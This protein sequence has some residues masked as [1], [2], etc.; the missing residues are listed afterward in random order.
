MFRTVGLAIAGATLLTLSS[1]AVPATARP[2]E[3]KVAKRLAETG[4]YPYLGPSVAALGPGDVWV[5]D[6]RIHHWNGRRWRTVRPTGTGDKRFAGVLAASKNDVWFITTVDPT[7]QDVQM[8]HWNGRRWR[9]SKPTKDYLGPPRDVTLMP[10][11]D[12]WRTSDFP[13]YS[14]LRL[15]NGKW[16]TTRLLQ[17]TRSIAG[18]SSNDLWAVGSAL[19]RARPLAAHWNGRS[20]RNTPLPEIKHGS[21]NAVTIVS[22]NDIWAVG[23]QWT[24]IDP[25]TD[26][27]DTRPLAMRWNGRSWRKVPTKPLG[28][29]SFTHVAPDGRG[30]VWAALGPRLAH[31]SN[32]SW[33][34]TRAPLGTRVSDLARTPGTTTLWATVGSSTDNALIRLRG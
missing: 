19:E 12:L 25:R 17:D 7:F 26:E 18:R 10:N 33:T 20:W 8:V 11:G 5:A 14:V 2:P 6:G 4:F 21:L 15:R 24:D 23:E 13:A 29:G 9:W 30:G 3:W 16:K 22:P 28:L 34:T 1:A 31:Y 27:L 32:G